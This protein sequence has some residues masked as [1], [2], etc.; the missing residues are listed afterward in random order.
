MKQYTQYGKTFNVVTPDEFAAFLPEFQERIELP[1]NH[2][3]ERNVVNGTIWYCHEYFGMPSTVIA[4]V[5]SESPSRVGQTI[6]RLR[7]SAERTGVRPSMSSRYQ[8]LIELA[9][10]VARAQGLSNKS[11][12]QMD[13]FDKEYQLWLVAN[14]F[15]LPNSYTPDEEPTSFLAN[16][17]LDEVEGLDREAA[18]AHIV[19]RYGLY[20]LDVFKSQ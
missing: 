19:K 14:E 10:D 6:K 20:K 7:E 18:V 16:R 4:A 3:P 5:L 11:I 1:E 9:D 2:I 17:V 12:Y 13:E 15:G 8:E